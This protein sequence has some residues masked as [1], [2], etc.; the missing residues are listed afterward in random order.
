M[1]WDGSGTFS[2]TNGVN[3]GSETWQDDAASDIKIRADRH[4]THDEDLSTGINACLTQNNENKPTAHF[5][6]NVNASYNLG[7][8]TFQWADGFFS[9]N[10]L[11]GGTLGVT[12]VATLPSP[13]INTSV[14]G[15]AILDE[16]DLI[17][18]SNT[19]L[20]T[21]QSIKAYV[22]ANV[23]GYNR[24]WVSGGA[25]STGSLPTGWSII[26]YTGGTCQIQM[27]TGDSLTS[28][29]I[30]IIP[31]DLSGDTFRRGN[32]VYINQ[33]TAQSAAD[34]FDII[35]EDDTGTAA[36]VASFSFIIIGV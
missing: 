4:D 35:I 6:P 23:L 18:D 19:Q 13:V 31:R 14:S 7:S 32:I 22:D 36:T 26:S 33:S 15:T 11:I 8:A 25:L 5:L 20:A 2:R 21:Q 30:S 28:F 24:G 10:V 29:A 3:T 17:S 1:G 16:D 9:G 27:N 34:Q 12:G